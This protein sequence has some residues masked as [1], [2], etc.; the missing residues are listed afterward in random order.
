MPSATLETSSIPIE[1]RYQN[2]QNLMQ[3]IL[4]KSIGFNTTLY[5]IWIGNSDCFWYERES[6]NGKEYRL[7]D[8][9][10]VTNDVAFDH[11]RLAAA[12]AEAVKQEI[13][14][15]N[16]PINNIDMRF[17]SPS[18]TTKKID[19]LHFTAFDKHWVFNTETETCQCKEEEPLCEDW[20]ISPD[21]KYVAFVKDFNLWVRE[22]SSGEERALTQDG[23]AL[24]VYGV[25]GSA[26]GFP[27]ETAVQAR[28]SNDSKRIFT[29]QR[30]TRRVKDLPV[31]QHVP[32][33]GSLRPVVEHYKVAYPGDEHIETQRLVCIEVETGRLQQANYRQ[34][35]VTRNSWGLFTAKLGWWSMDNRRAY[36]VDMERDYKTVRLVEFDT[37]TGGTKIL[38]EETTHTQIN[39]MPNADELPMLVPLPETGELL[40]FS[41]RSDWGHLYLYDLDSGALKNTVTKGDWLVRDILHIDTHRRE[42]FIQTAGRAADRDPYYR[43]V[44]RVHLDTG[45]M[46]PLISSDHDIN[47]IIQSQLATLNM[48]V[49]RDIKKSSAVSP[50][51]NFAVVTQSRADETPISFLV[52]RDGRNILELE[53]AD[54]SG[55]PDGWQWPE[56]V[57][58]LAA[59]GKTDIYGLVFRPSDFSPDKSY[60]VISHVFNTPELPWVAKGSFTN[61]TIPFAWAYFDAAALSE[62]GFVVVQIDGRGTA[63]RNKAFHDECYGRMESISN[64]DDHVAGIKQL[65]KRYPFM[66]LQRVGITS[67]VT[68][69]PG[70]IQGLLQH[71]DFYTV[72]VNLIPHDSRLMSASMWGEKYEGVSGAN[73][74]CLYPEE[75]VEKLQGKLLLIHGMLDA[76]SP[77]AITFRLVE[78]LQ[79]ANKDF[80]LVLLPN[81]GHGSNGYLLRR[82]WDYLVKHLLGT[83]A[84]KEFKLTTFLDG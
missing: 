65:A 63:F 74:D 73:A 68:G 6:K 56:P 49:F 58:L 46:T 50:S 77:P 44:C 29:V 22:I 62:L 19:T 45:E 61:N 52:D 23:E 78:A 2:A 30:D 59:D 66:D 32:L 38:F 17:D 14:A 28:W 75:M 53:T 27:V 20:V 18:S 81:L 47:A 9:T 84:P 35:P 54:I 57:K 71:P 37:H 51:G 31:I 24:F 10:V 43:D 8:A 69:G 25:G 40:W 55:L 12:L 36:F 83:V 80:D 48:A 15:N 79:K 60:P 5:P 39:L 72:G 3:G 7:V 76:A 67:Q 1:I 64:L 41:E 70:G 82:S 4:T 34:I 33:D 42:V 26:W 13:D 16:L 11:S 21:G